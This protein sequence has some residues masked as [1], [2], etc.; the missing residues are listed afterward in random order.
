MTAY[1]CF[2]SVPISYGGYFTL[3]VSSMK[4]YKANLRK[5]QVLPQLQLLDQMFLFPPLPLYKPVSSLV[6][7]PTSALRFRFSD[8]VAKAVQACLPSTLEELNSF[9]P[10]WCLAELRE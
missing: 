5:K 7:K 3:T 9:C 6:L 8:C 10:M 2:S 4:N 1:L